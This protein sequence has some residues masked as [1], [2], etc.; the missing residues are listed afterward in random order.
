MA[1]GRVTKIGHKQSLMTLIVFGAT[2]FAERFSQ[3]LFFRI[4]FLASYIL[5]II[6]WLSAWAWSASVAGTWLSYTF[7]GDYYR[8]QAGALAA[9]AGLGALVW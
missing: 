2:I 7:A 3:Q 8:G 4:G 9:C 6:F 5:N 1:I